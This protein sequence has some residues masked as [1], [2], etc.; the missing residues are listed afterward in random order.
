MKDK[1]PNYRAT[2]SGMLLPREENDLAVISPHG[3]FTVE[4][5]VNY[6][7]YGNTLKWQAR[8]IPTMQSWREQ[9]K[10]HEE[11]QAHVKG[12]F[13]RQITDWAPHVEQAIPQADL[14][15]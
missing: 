6:N 13:E 2:F 1:P 12:I 7:L 10:T 5:Y 3:P 9:F 14:F 4:V 8:L 15:V 11:A